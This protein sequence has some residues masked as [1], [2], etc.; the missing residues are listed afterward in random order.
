MITINVLSV[1]L[2]VPWT[3]SSSRHF[4]PVKWPFEESNI[5][6]HC[7]LT[8]V[9]SLQFHLSLFFYIC[10]IIFAFLKHSFILKMDAAGSSE[11]LGTTNWSTWR[12]IAEESKFCRG[13]SFG[14]PAPWSPVTFDIAKRS[15][16]TTADK[17]LSLKNKYVK[18][19]LLLLVGWDWVH[20]VLRSLL[21]YCTSPRW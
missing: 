16:F 14:P 18:L 9:C 20:L 12:H 11:M 1:F 5:L 19:S 6:L 10:I 21:A 7:L 4:D 8:P 13:F 17:F 15:V 2:L 3:I